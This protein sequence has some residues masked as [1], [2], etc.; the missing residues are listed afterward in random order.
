MK[1]LKGLFVTHDFGIYGA[2]KSLKTLISSGCFE[3]CDLVYPLSLLAPFRKS[4]PTAVKME[5]GRSINQVFRFFLPFQGCCIEV[6]EARSVMAR[7]EIC[8]QNFLWRLNSRPFYRW[9]KK[10]KYDFIHLNSIVLHQMIR[11]SFPFFL[12]V[13]EFFNGSSND[14]FQSLE[15]ARGVFFIDSTVKKPFQ[16]LKLKNSEVLINPIH[17]EKNDWLL[18]RSA[19]RKESFPEDSV[20][21]GVIGRINEE[22][23]LPFLLKAFLDCPR[24]DLILLIVGEGDPSLVEDLKKLSQNDSR[25]V[26]WGREENILSVYSKLDYVLRGESVPRFGR[27]HFEGLFLGCGIISPEI[28]DSIISTEIREFLD[29]IVFYQTRDGR[30]L[31]RVLNSIVK[32]PLENRKLKSNCV[33]VAQR[34][35]EVIISSTK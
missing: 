30:D 20:I 15:K 10:Q 29:K 16:H 12:H 8:F 27:T 1:R 26:F 11:T 28:S 24:K 9:L 18:E 32:V 4:S 31:L 5:L 7:T 19:V 13:R 17:F 22:K 34:F 35:L 21:L 33:E 3:E 6:P 23:G 25:V 2:S 14:C